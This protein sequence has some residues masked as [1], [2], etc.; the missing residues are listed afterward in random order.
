MNAGR[1]LDA[2]VAVKV[3]RWKVVPARGGHIDKAYESYGQFEPFVAYIQHLSGYVAF[4]NRESIIG[5]WKR[6]SPSRDISDA[7]DVVEKMTGCLPEQWEVWCRELIHEEQLL[8]R[9]KSAPLAICRAA[10]KAMKVLA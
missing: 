8:R 2:I 4:Q 6:W 5:N 9:P 3:L 10:L 7:W 1:K